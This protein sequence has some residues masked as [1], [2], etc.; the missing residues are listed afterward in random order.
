MRFPAAGRRLERLKRR[1]KIWL[2]VHLYLGLS[3]GAVLLL[4]GLT[5]SL[6]VFWLEI[7]RWLN[8]ALTLVAKSDISFGLKPMQDIVA[9]AT[10]AMP[11]NAVFS[12]VY[13]PHFPEMAYF[14]SSMSRR[15]NLGNTTR[16]MYSSIPTRRRFWGLAPII[17]PTAL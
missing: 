15:N 1:R 9:A 5:G 10:A 7:D 13:P 4:V 12:Y 16:S 8:P 2:T 11:A 6:L 17:P 14:F 3:V